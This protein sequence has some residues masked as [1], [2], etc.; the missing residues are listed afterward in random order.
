MTE[1]EKGYEQG[2]KDGMIGAALP[3]VNDNGDK[4]DGYSYAY[5]TDSNGE[6]YIHIDSVRGMLK[7]ADD[8]QPVRHGRWISCKDKMPEDNTSVLFVYVSENGVKSVHYGYHQ[9]L[10]G[11][12]SSWAKPSGGRQ[13]CDDDITHWQP[14]PEP[15]EDGDAE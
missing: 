14:L 4:I 11:L 10:K 1:F 2:Y 6:P 12:G 7:K 8:V 9:T 13:Y 5:K 15:P 3:N